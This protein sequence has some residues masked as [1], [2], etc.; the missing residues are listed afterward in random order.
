MSGVISS[1]AAREIASCT[2]IDRHA[3]PMSY[4]VPSAR[5]ITVEPNAATAA[6]CTS[7]CVS[8]PIVL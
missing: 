2:V 7:D 6:P 4:S 5:R 8:S 1:P 3:P